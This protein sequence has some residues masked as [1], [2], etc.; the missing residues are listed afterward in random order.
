MA[1]LTEQAMTADLLQNSS[2]TLRFPF[3]HRCLTCGEQ[4]Q[5]EETGRSRR[6]CSDA[7]RQRGYR[8]RRREGP[9]WWR[10]RPWHPEAAR[11]EA[12]RQA[13]Y[14]RQAA[15]R[16]AT[17]Q[18]EQ[19][20]RAVRLAAMPPHVREGV[21][22]AQREQSEQ[23]WRTFDREMGRLQRRERGIGQ[24]FFERVGATAHQMGKVVALDPVDDERVEKLMNRAV[25]TNSDDEAAACLAKARAIW[26]GM[27][28]P[29]EPK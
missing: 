10:S 3:L 15:E 16:K 11:E 25:A 24:R 6:Y 28:E 14:A 29:E 22:R 7:C 4:V 26:R 13:K 18:R 19:Q 23:Y 20:A 21:M 2:V 1:E 17:D 5:V 8:L 9:N 12:E 27:T